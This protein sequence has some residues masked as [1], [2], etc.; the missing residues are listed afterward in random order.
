MSKTSNKSIKSSSS[1]RNN[2]STVLV[3][4]LLLIL[5]PIAVFF[6]SK[7]FIFDHIFE[8][9]QSNIFAAVSA[10]ITLHICLG[11]LL[12]CDNRRIKFSLHFVSVTG[13]Y[14]YRAWFDTEEKET[15]KQD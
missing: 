10:I 7:V 2:F 9:I 15:Q 1:D 12:S 4:C 11:K 13:L 6:S 5:S 14:I 3:Y 8:S